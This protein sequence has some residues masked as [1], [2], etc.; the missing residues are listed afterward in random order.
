MKTYQKN[1]NI[2]ADFI[3]E[4]APNIFN[5]VEIINKFIIDLQC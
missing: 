5:V 2:N 3:K 1:Q 4:N